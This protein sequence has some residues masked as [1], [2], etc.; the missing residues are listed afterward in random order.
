MK[1][2]LLAFVLG[3]FCTITVAEQYMPM[4]VKWDRPYGRSDGTQLQP[5]EPIFYMLWGTI[6]AGQN[7]SE[8]LIGAAIGGTEF[9]HLLDKNR[10]GLAGGSVSY[11]VKACDKYP[12][13]GKPTAEN[14]S[15]SSNLQGIKIKLAYAP[16]PPPSEAEWA[17]VDA[18]NLYG[19]SYP[20][21]PPG[22]RP[23]TEPPPG[24]KPPPRNPKH[25]PVGP[26]KETG[27]E[28]VLGF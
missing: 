24:W 7:D 16:D 20:K 21:A 22:W 19:I 27:L 26:P 1:H 13:E 25:P 9:I 18:P 14:C 11:R 12:P 6:N 4:I 3:M 23:P 28:G 17:P 5:D 10:T 15:E 2:L 8:R